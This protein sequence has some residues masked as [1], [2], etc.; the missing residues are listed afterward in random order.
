MEKSDRIDKF[1]YFYPQTVAM[2]GV[3]NN[4]MPAAWHTPVSGQPPLYGILI[5][6]KRYT[7]DLLNREN[8]FTVNF[9]EHDHAQLCAWTGGISG[10]DTDKFKEFGISCFR[11]DTVNGPILDQC[12]A[13]YECKKHSVVEYGDHYLF[14]GE[15]VL[16]HYRKDILNIDRLIDEKNVKPMLYFGRDRYI[17]TDPH[18]IVICK[19]Q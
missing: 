5:S 11:A 16:I 4:I 1:Y 2:I 7:Y 10:R 12:Y 18:R 6:P 19:K 9:L 8:G 3:N 15:I 14:I 13:A 17:T